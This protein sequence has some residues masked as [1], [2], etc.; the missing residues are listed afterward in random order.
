MPRPKKAKAKEPTN[1]DLVQ[2]ASEVWHITEKIRALL[3]DAARAKDV[4]F[5]DKASEALTAALKA[6]E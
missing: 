2:R 5:F 3:Q 4:A 1:A 6:M